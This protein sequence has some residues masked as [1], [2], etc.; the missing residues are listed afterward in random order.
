M[1]LY[2]QAAHPA[3]VGSPEAVGM[4]FGPYPY[5]EGDARG[6]VVGSRPVELFGSLQ[7]AFP[8]ESIFRT[9]FGDVQGS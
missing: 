8:D 9:K 1:L 4:N 2:S 5:C 6:L 3:I 7:R